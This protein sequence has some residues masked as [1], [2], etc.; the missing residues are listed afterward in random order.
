MESYNNELLCF[1]FNLAKSVNMTPKVYFVLNHNKRSCEAVKNL[2]NDGE[3]SVYIIGGTEVQPSKKRRL[4]TTAE[5]NT[6]VDIRSPNPCVSKEGETTILYED[7]LKENEGGPSNPLNNAHLLSPRSPA[8]NPAIEVKGLSS[9]SGIVRAST[10][11][12]SPINCRDN[13]QE[14]AEESEKDAADDEQAIAPAD[15]GC[16]ITPVKR[17]RRRRL[18]LN[19][20][21]GI[22]SQ[23][24][25]PNNQIS[26][27][28]DVTI[29]WDAE[30]AGAL[31]LRPITSYRDSGS[32]RGVISAATQTLKPGP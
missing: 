11:L 7:L 30:P 1:G 4:P 16:A 3:M 13:P 18:K 17:N 14:T 21:P 10:P 25:P 9:S 23:N 28:I 19:K 6:T 32:L 22:L 8:Y 31:A 29:S 26:E 24:M 15:S 5:A 27:A 12:A 2:G 20:K